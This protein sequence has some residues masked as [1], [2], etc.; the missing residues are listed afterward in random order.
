VRSDKYF[1]D[2]GPPLLDG[3]GLVF[4]HRGRETPV[5]RAVDLCVRA[6]D[7]LLLQ[8]ASGGGK[9]TLAALLAG[10]RRPEAGL[11]LLHGLDRQTLG[12][13][14]WRRR[15]VLVPQ[16]HDNHVFLGTL[17]FNLF[18]PCHTPRTRR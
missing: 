5:L 8:G 14:G 9:S 11:L 6:G 13:D 10:A 15:V 18:P 16:F 4:R 2:A 3:R 1:L 17:A 12:G 7:R